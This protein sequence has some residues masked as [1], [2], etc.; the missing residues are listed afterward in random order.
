MAYADCRRRARAT[1]SPTGLPSPHRASAAARRAALPAVVVASRE[2]DDEPLDAAPV[3]PVQVLHAPPRGEGDPGAQVGARRDEDVV[4]VA[5][6]DALELVDVAARGRARVLDQHVAVLEV[7][8]LDLV[9]YRLPVDARGG[10][11]RDVRP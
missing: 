11:P 4:Q 6:R 8:D 10:D 2:I 5:P 1:A 9:R 3:G 7:V